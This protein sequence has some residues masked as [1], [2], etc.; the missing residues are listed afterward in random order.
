MA[1]TATLTAAAT[2][3]VATEEVDMAVVEVVA[4]PAVLVVV[5]EWPTSAPA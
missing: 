2:E 4:A 1:P 3:A 5:T